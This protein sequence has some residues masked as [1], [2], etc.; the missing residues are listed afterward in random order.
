[1]PKNTIYY[2][3]K[4]EA[5][6]KIN[7]LKSNNKIHVAVING[8]KVKTWKQYLSQIQAIY[9]FPTK[10]DNFDGYADWMQDLSWIEHD[11]YALFILDYD[12]FMIQEPQNKKIVMSIFLTQIL[13]WWQHDVELYCLGGEP[14]EFNV[15]LVSSFC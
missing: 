7:E 5:D 3:S 6:N 2:I 14:K 11:A 9:N 10:N 8:N 13:P 4:E 15:Y 12:D 1:M